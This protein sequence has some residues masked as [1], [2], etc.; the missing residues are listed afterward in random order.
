MEE[1]S[2]SYYLR[3]SAIDKPGVLA[4]IA[5]VLSDNNISIANVVQ[6]E[7][8]E[9]EIVPVVILTHKAKEGSM[10]K[11]IIEIDKKDCIKKKTVV[12]RIEE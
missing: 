1:L 9:G 2:I 10:R 11:A 8:N 5:S 7:R 12:I 4:E 3:F 6:E